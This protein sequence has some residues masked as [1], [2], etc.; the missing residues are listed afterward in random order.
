MKDLLTSEGAGG[1]A[2]TES[3]VTEVGR[4]RANII[5]FLIAK[6]NTRSAN[7]E[8]RTWCSYGVVIQHRYT[9][10][11]EETHPVRLLLLYNTYRWC[12]YRVFRYNLVVTGRWT[13]DSMV[14][15]RD[16]HG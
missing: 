8:G 14:A 4:S 7:S 1:R 10:E 16:V 13:F 2:V 3:M 11:K 6:E 12:A 15:S 9:L 5:T